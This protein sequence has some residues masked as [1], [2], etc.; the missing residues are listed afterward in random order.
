MPDT[1]HEVS[2][3]AVGMAPSRNA[4]ARPTAAQ[5]APAPWRVTSTEDGGNFDEF[6]IESPDR[7]Y[8]HV[9]V[10]DGN[11]AVAAFAYSAG[12]NLKSDHRLDAIR[13]LIL[14][15]HDLLSALRIVDK[16]LRFGHIKD[17]SI[18]DRNSDGP[19]AKIKPLSEIVRA[20]IAK[21]TT[22]A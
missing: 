12:H 14:A 4:A 6:G 7:D 10:L 11:N 9:I 5:L 21:A 18:L 8:Q 17:Q 3:A 13:D 1:K 15:A 22:G 20:A 2:S 16:G 19:E